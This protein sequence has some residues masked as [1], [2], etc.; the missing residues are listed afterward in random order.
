MLQGNWKFWP[1]QPCLPQHRSP[2]RYTHLLWRFR[3]I[4]SRINPLL[5]CTYFHN[6]FLIS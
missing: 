2:H 1:A 6:I 5:L 4:F 3:F